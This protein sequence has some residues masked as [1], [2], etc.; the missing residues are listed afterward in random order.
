MDV[1]VARWVVS[2]EAEPFLTWAGQA[3]EP[4]SLRV[5]EMLRRELPPER[6]AA[7]LD[8]VSLRGR[9]S[10]KLGEISP[11]V[12]L[13]QDSLEQATRWDVAQWRARRLAGLGITHVID[14]GCGVGIDS[15]GF[16]VAGASVSG[17]ERDPVLAVF[18]EANLAIKTIPEGSSVVVR[19]LTQSLDWLPTSPT[20]AL[21]LDPARRT[22]RG[23]SWDIADLSPSW[24]FVQ[25]AIA[26][27]PGPAVVKLAPGFPRHLIP[28][29]AA[30][31]WVSHGGDL[32]ETT[33]WIGTGAHREAVVLNGSTP[34]C[35]AEGD[36]L[37][38]PGPIG[39]YIYEPD[40]A[41]I[42]AHAIPT[43]AR[44]TSAHPLAD[45]IAYL[46]SDTLVPTQFA[47]AFQVEQVMDFSQRALKSWVRANEIGAVEIKVRGLDIDPATFRRTLGL[48][49]KN[50]ASII[51]TPTPSGAKA[52]IV[53]RIPPT[54]S[55][56]TV[57]E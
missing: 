5:G 34:A 51:L 28:K 18:A 8:L 46:T 23:R 47:Q 30:V 21:F 11:F 1:E 33:L 24:E 19:D 38:P 27:T 43:L 45:S 15:L 3:G 49:G 7:V 36:T 12:F 26:R 55:T 14:A 52:V 41:V 9:A 29:E 4:S 50:S 17:I 6:A 54:A 40:P 56:Q 44:I 10:R 39:D 57:S 31:T 37:P 22:T 20:S 13:T 35:I 53:R 42:R 2:G 48:K 25:Q 16:R 32:V